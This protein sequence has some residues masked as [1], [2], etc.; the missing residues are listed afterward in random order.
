M[1]GDFFF[2][3]KI[4]LLQYCPDHPT[5]PPSSSSFSHTADSSE[6]RAMLRRL[7]KLIGFPEQTAL[8]LR[9]FERRLFSS[10]SVST[11][12]AGTAFPLCPE[13]EEEGRTLLLRPRKERRLFEKMVAH[14]YLVSIVRTVPVRCVQYILPTRSKMFFFLCQQIKGGLWR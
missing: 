4:C 10:V 6:T 13:E 5:Q 1:T 14:F 7:D 3:Q 9:S 2:S 8:M 12:L 11:L